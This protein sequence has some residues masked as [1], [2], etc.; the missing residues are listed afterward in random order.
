[1]ESNRNTDPPKFPTALSLA[2]AALQE[3]QALKKRYSKGHKIDDMCTLHTGLP[4]CFT[5]RKP[6]YESGT[7]RFMTIKG[8]SP[9]KHSSHVGEY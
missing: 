3:S 9:L 2:D 4:H 7:Y 8:T 6:G 1:M 5:V